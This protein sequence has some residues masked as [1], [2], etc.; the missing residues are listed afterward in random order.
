MMSDRLEIGL[1]MQANYSADDAEVNSCK[2]YSLAECE[3]NVCFKIGGTMTETKHNSQ[4][5]VVL[6]DPASAT[7]GQQPSWLSRRWPIML[8]CAVSV[9]WCLAYGFFRSQLSND[10][11]RDNGGGVPYTVFWVLLVAVFWPS[12]RF[13]LRISIL[14]VLAV[15]GLE[16]FQLYNPEPLAS[17]RRTRF[18][19]A[20]LGS[21]FVWNDI[22]PYFIGGLVGWA[23]LRGLAVC[24]NG[25][26]RDST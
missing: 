26:S 21:T 1:A 14:V 8:A 17:F 18:G 19:A 20:L 22:P 9:V 10:W 7:H 24:C 13:A 11:I 2:N 23:V 12:K 5:Q 15:C 25:C 6:A 16:F 3:W 4:P